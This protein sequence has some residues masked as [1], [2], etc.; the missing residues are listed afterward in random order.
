MDI[1]DWY[2]IEKWEV[3]PL[4][5]GCRESEWYRNSLTGGGAPEDAGPA[6][7]S[8]PRFEVILVALHRDGKSK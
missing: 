5:E 2:G 7:A 1:F 6:E 8:K 3:A 4:K